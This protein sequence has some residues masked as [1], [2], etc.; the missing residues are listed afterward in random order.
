LKDVSGQT[1]QPEPALNRETLL[2]I[3]RGA[4][5]ALAELFEFVFDR[6]YGLAF[7][8][9]GERAAAED[10]IQDVF[11]R[12]HRAAGSIDVDRDPLPWL[13][14]ITANL[15]RD[16]WRSFAT[17]VSTRSED[18]DDAAG[19]GGSLADR[20]HDPEERTLATEREVSVQ[21]AIDTLPDDLREVVILRDRPWRH[22]RD[23]RRQPCGGAQAILTGSGPARGFAEGR[24]AMNDHHDNQLTDRQRHAA[25]AVRSLS[26]PGA[27][28]DFRARLKADFVSG[29]LDGGAPAP[30]V[31]L[32]RTRRRWLMWVPLAAAAAMAA[33]LFFTG[34][35][36]GPE[37]LGSHTAGTV[38]VDGRAVSPADSLLL[39][40]LLRP[41][42]VVELRDGA[43]LD[44][45]YP[46]SL[47]MRLATG[48]TFTLPDHPRRWIGR[49]IEAE[50][51]IGEVSIRTGPDFAGNLLA[52]RTPEGR[53]RIYGTL[54]SVF[55]NADL[56]CVCL[57]EGTAVMDDRER[58]LGSIPPGKRWV[59]YEDG[60]EAEL[61]DI[62]P[63][64]QAQMEG[65]VEERGDCF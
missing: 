15:C 38:L 65:L 17:K 60:R 18:V 16:H 13:R 56:T 1:T 22:R 63:P 36:P 9:L 3:R 50:L 61:L 27:R 24:V 8:M 55:R 57:Y 52:I 20:E 34:R 11:L 28:P 37:V 59:L 64:H 2:A 46:G 47:V 32:D 25:E 62:A 48:T 6:L 35:L 4:P 31:R 7:R 49:D 42:A 58:E 51:A 26:R 14:S 29:A 10:V 40:D 43:E 53:A 41:G 19:P 54:I 33:V 39:D 45:L 12:L 21:V 23:R 30:V 44:L 5:E